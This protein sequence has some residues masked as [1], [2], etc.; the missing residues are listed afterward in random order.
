MSK[1]DPFENLQPHEEVEKE[2]DEL[3]GSLFYDRNSPAGWTMLDGLQMCGSVI[4]SVAEIANSTAAFLAEPILHPMD[5]PSD[6]IIWYHYAHVAIT[7][8]A[9]AMFAP[10]AETIFRDFSQAFEGNLN[11]VHHGRSPGI[12]KGFQKIVRSTNKYEVVPPHV[13]RRLEALFYYRNIGL[14]Q[15][16]EWS[17][18]T[19]RR[20]LKR[21]K[22]ECKNLNVCGESW[23]KYFMPVGIGDEPCVLVCMTGKYVRKLM[24]VALEELVK[25]CNEIRESLSY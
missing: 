13:W 9:T 15:G 8:V 20:F 14:H 18:E 17:I 12:L 23:N 2:R 16:L 19:R 10:L 22:K 5:D 24:P 6:S 11:Q 25:S 4:E 7:H 1:H 3:G 21:Y